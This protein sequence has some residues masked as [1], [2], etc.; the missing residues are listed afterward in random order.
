MRAV[1]SEP[2]LWQTA[3]AIRTRLSADGRPVPNIAI[4]GWGSRSDPRAILALFRAIIVFQAD[5]FIQRAGLQA[6]TWVV[7][8]VADYLIIRSD[9]QVI[10]TQLADWMYAEVGRG[11][12]H[13]GKPVHLIGHTAGGFV[14]GE[15]GWQVKNLCEDLRVTL[16]DTP[17]P[18]YDHLWR[19]PA[20]NRELDR[21]VSSAFGMFEY[22]TTIYSETLSTHHSRSILLSVAPTVAGPVI[23]SILAHS[24][25]HEWHR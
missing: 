9:G 12:I 25:A 23:P 21:Y 24:C 7:N 22:V 8:S 15:A 20:T 17:F 3:R 1:E 10:G 5:G 14:V 4:L 2:W 16:L 11:N 6:S 18:Y 13:I 19:F